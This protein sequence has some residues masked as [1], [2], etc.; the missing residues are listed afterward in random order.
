MNKHLLDALK[1]AHSIPLDKTLA[2][3]VGIFP[4]DLSGI[5]AERGK[6]GATLILRIHERFGKPVREIRQLID[7]ERAT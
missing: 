5:R 1:E 2:Y 4:N 6:I 7:L 3:E